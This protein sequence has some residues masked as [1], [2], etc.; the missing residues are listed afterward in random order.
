MCVY[1]CAC[2]C[3]CMCM[4]A[5]SNSEKTGLMNLKKTKERY[6][7]GFGKKKGNERNIVIKLQ[8]KKY[9]SPVI[10]CND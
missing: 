5:F 8:V 1:V 7:K 4:R 9:Q 6:V 3:V 2:V 10:M